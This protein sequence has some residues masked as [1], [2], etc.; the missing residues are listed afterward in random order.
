M[1]LSE[2][3]STNFGS[4]PS[5]SAMIRPMSTSKPSTSSVCGF[6]KPNGGTS[7]FTPIVISPRSWILPIVVSAG[8]CS[9]SAA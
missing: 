3:A 4:T 7:N 2:I 1:R 8:N 9:A 5:S 6:L